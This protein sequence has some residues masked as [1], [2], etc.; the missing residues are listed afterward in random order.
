MNSCLSSY[1]FVS[2]VLPGMKTE[3]KE[4]LL[5]EILTSME[6]VAVAY[7]GGV[8]STYL[9]KIAYDLLGEH[10]V[11]LTAVSASLPAAEL[12]E[13]Q[14]IARQVGVQHVLID[15]H[16]TEDPSYLAN[17]P[18]R[19]YFCK[20]E[21][22]KELA[23][24]ARQH[25]YRWIADGSNW[26]D[27]GDHRPGRQAAQ[28]HGVRSPLLEAELTKQEIRQLARR[29]GLPNWDKPAAA[30]LSSR[31]PYGTLITLENLELVE[32]AERVLRNL[33]L[34]QVRVRHHDHTARIEVDIYDLQA[35]LSH[36]ETIL[37]QLQ[38]L[39]YTYVTL[40]LAGFRSGSLNAAINPNGHLKNRDSA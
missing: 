10:A 7:S 3:K 15:S 33:G 8:D 36:R 26:D 11:A 24:Y 22:Y 31:I 9:M 32:R 38:S 27:L 23:D 21:V 14:Q 13:A 18:A 25:G 12:A 29:E 28:E 16:E 19:C 40:D 5:Q 30:C 6:S 4:S 2:E 37:S 17:S 34:R 20:H 1:R 39:G 35:V